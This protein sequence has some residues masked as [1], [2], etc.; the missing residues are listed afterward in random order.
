VL[1]LHDMHGNVWEWCWDWYGSYTADAQTDPQGAV[2]GAYRV[3]RGGSWQNNA[4]F[5]RSAS[6]GSSAPAFREATIGLRIVR[7]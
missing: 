4:R 3:A 2:I 1:G 7:P 6:R 5:L